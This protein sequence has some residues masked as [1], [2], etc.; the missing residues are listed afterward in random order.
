MFDLSSNPT[1]IRT[2]H[3]DDGAKWDE[4]GA[5]VAIDGNNVLIGAPEDD[6]KGEDTGSAYLFNINNGKQLRKFLPPHEVKKGQ[7]R[8]KS[9][10]PWEVCCHC[11]LLQNRK[12]W[13][14]LHIR[15]N[16]L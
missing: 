5:S 8:G 4:F 1:M 13:I 7:V 10:T 9:G 6:D 14:C 12:W 3:A 11:S 16:L 2:F 15:Y